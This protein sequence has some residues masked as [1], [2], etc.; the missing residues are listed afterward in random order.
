MTRLL[1]SA[2]ALI[3]LSIAAGLLAGVM[4]VA[5]GGGEPHPVSIER[6]R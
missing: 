2:P 4:F 1:Q 3:A 5:M 6:N